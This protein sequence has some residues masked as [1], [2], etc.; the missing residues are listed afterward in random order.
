[1]IKLRGYRERQQ[2]LRKLP[3]TPVHFAV[4]KR[5]AL[6]VCALAL[7]CACGKT[8]TSTARVFLLE[9]SLAGEV[10][11]FVAA[12]RAAPP[13]PCQVLFVVSSSFVEWRKNLA[14]DMAPMPVINR[15]FGGSH[16]E[17]VN[18][19][20]DEIVAPYRPRAIVFYAGDNDIDAGKSVT[21][22]VADFDTF[23][24]LK[25][26]SFGGDPRLFHFGQAFNVAP[27]AA[28]AANRGQ[29]CDSCSRGPARRPALHRC[30]I[31]DA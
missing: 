12:D 8:Q 25:T 6:S 2:L 17:Y 7:L 3:M 30:G 13:A 16:I 20:F 26:H 23:M 4:F 19:W 10:D 24:A 9:F 21:R 1:M 14:A 31:A 27:G 18:R 11:R 5:L 22:V 29:R 15:G 28:S